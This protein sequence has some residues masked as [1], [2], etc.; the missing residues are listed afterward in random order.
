ML[1]AEVRG[2]TL[3]KGGVVLHPARWNTYPRHYLTMASQSESIWQL[4]A[5]DIS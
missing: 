4:M 5:S 1:R 2:L 3:V